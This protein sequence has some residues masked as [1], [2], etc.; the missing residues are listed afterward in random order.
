MNLG[1]YIEAT[2]GSERNVQIYN[3]LNSAV[4]NKEVE[5]ACVF[6]NNVDHNPV[7]PRFGL[8]NGTDIWHFTGNLIATSIG[9][10]QKALKSVNKFDLAYLYDPAEK[11]LFGLLELIG[12]VDVLAINEEEAKEFFRLTGVQPKVLSSLTVKDI[13]QVLS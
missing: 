3:A 10:V 2:N 6:F 7:H 5:D 12:R 8:F 9:N 1:F 13:K 4:D 11:N